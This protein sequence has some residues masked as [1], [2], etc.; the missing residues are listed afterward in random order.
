MQQE[1]GIINYV[2]GNKNNLL[3]DEHY[4]LMKVA[5]NLDDLKIKLQN[6]IYGKYLLEAKMSLAAF[7]SAMYKCIDE[8][9]QIT[10]SFA[11]KQSEVLINFYKEK[12]QLDNFL[13][14]W[15]CKKE[16]PKLLETEL[17]TH[18]LGGYPG[19]NFIKVTQT[20]K[21]T[22]KYCL[23]NTSLSKYVEG[24]TYE[25]LNKDIQYVK[26]ILQKRYLELVYG[27]CIKN[28]LCLEELIVFEGD[29]VIIEILYALINTNIPSTEKLNL[30]PSCN[31][32]TQVHKELL[33]NCKSISELEGILSTHS[34]YR[35][36]VGNETG[37]EDALLREEIRLCN[38]SFYIYD[39]YSVIYTQLVLQEIEVRNLVFLADC[40]IQGHDHRDEIVNVTEN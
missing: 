23:E 35:N 25:L 21:D 31:S 6:T 26:S 13:Y 2:H 36:I 9:I 33:I 16:S 18:P 15:A 20:A 39:D 24:L 40:V 19:L 8:Q 38:K 37:I 11:T 4:R 17:N 12:Y 28:R 30:F 34:K 7:K 27:Y 10:Q 29:K 22:W 1:T 14:L 5:N 3:K 32:F